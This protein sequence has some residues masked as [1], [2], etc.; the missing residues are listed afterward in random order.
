MISCS[1]VIRRGYSCSDNSL[2]LRISQIFRNHIYKFIDRHHMLLSMEYCLRITNP[3]LDV[4]LTKAAGEITPAKA[5]PGYRLLFPGRRY[6]F[7]EAQL[8][9]SATKIPEAR[10]RIFCNHNSHNQSRLLSGE[11]CSNHTINTISVHLKRDLSRE[12][13]A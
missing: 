1:V 2:P 6:R 13:R 5:L 9:R 7:A 3:Q 11:W 12:K 8:N 10:Q 4:G